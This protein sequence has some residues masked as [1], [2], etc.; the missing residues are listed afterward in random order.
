M[1][2]I[3]TAPYSELLGTFTNDILTESAS[4]Q[5]RMKLDGDLDNTFKGY[6][7]EDT[8]GDFEADANKYVWDHFDK[9]L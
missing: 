8:N 7:G 9:G 6:G 4:D 3:Y 2:K 5:V 1:K